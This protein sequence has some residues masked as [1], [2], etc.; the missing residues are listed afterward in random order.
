MSEELL[1]KGPNM[2]SCSLTAQERSRLSGAAFDLDEFS[3]F[4]ARNWS[5]GVVRTVMKAVEPLWDGTGITHDRAS[6][7]FYGRGHGRVGTSI[8]LDQ[9]FVALR[10]AAKQWLPP[11]PQGSGGRYDPARGWTIDDPIGRLIKFQLHKFD[12]LGR[13]QPGQSPSETAQS[14]QDEDVA[15]LARALAEAQ[16]APWR[17]ASR[18]TPPAASPNRTPTKS[19]GKRPRADADASSSHE[20]VHGQ[21]EAELKRQLA[22]AQAEPEALQ[23]LSLSETR[24]LKHELQSALERCHQREE[25]L[26]RAEKECVICYDRTKAIAFVPCGHLVACETCDHRAQMVRCPICQAAIKQRVRIF[27]A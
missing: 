7:T 26:E 1:A 20:T 21:R 22:L 14:V 27:N 24:L 10:A 13:R 8:S 12:Q 6:G 2:P 5:P 19:S 23:K 18:S 16:S 15:A 17:L 11:R 9:D 3:R 25:R 4:L